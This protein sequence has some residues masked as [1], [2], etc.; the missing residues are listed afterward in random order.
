[1]QNGA[2]VG[3]RKLSILCTLLA[4]SASPL[5]YA[6]GDDCTFDQNYQIKRV[7]EMA[8]R[9]PGGRMSADRRMVSWRSADGSVLSVAHGGCADLGTTIRLSY[10]SGR[11]PDNRVALRRLFAAVS[12]YWSPADAKDMVA[13]F[14]SGAF[15]ARAQGRELVELELVRS[16]DSPFPLGLTVSITPMELAVTWTQG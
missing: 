1:M 3:P 9:H 12:A 16:E 13:A 4:L 10:P 14:A 2:F 7:A 8:A 11:R 5:L 15:T 6:G